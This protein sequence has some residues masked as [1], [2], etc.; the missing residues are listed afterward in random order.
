METKNDDVVDKLNS[1]IKLDFDAI[2]AYEAA[3]EKIETPTYREQ[4]SRYCDD[5]LRH[6]RELSAIVSEYG[7]TAATGPDI[8]RLLTKG[9][10]VIADLIGN[11]Q[12]ILTA[13]YANEE[14]TNKAYEAA[15]SNLDN[16][17]PETRAQLESN[18]AD[19]RGHR[20]WLDQQIEK[21]K[22]TA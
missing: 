16:V 1:L 12:A 15:L 9:K 11:D 10:V 21:E 6:V 2:E 14:I 18:L 5:H 8:K 4:L 20:A 3:I 22:A 13:M 19:E 7:G 17:K